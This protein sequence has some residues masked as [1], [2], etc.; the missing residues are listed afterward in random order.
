[1]VSGL[2]LLAGEED[3]EKLLDE[4]YDSTLLNSLEDTPDVTSSCKMAR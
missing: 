3:L 1:V 2:S 4:E